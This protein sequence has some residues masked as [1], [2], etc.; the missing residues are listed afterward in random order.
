MLEMPAEELEIRFRDMWGNNADEI[1]MLYAGTPAL[2]G[3]FTRTG[4]RTKV[5]LLQDG[6]NAAIRYVVNNFQDHRRQEAVDLLLGTHRPAE[7]EKDLLSVFKAPLDL[8]L[9]IPLGGPQPQPELVS[10]E[11]RGDSISPPSSLSPSEDPDARVI[12]GAGGIGGE[13]PVGSE[14]TLSDDG[15]V[16]GGGGGGG[17]RWLV[18][19]REGREPT[20]PLTNLRMAGAYAPLSVLALAILAIRLFGFPRSLH[21]EVLLLLVGLVVIPIIHVAEGGWSPRGVRDIL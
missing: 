7:D 18:E 2:K 4:K 21:M 6:T 16:R 17:D 20:S 3:D 11:D 8:D 19:Q 14:A 12:L 10:K 13:W 15:V 9:W 1:S 5:G